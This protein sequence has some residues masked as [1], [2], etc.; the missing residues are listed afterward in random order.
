[1]KKFLTVIAISLITFHISAK[2]NV[3]VILTDDQGWG[4]LSINGNTAIDTPNVDRL[5]RDGAMFDRFYV[6]PVCAPTRAEFLTGRH[7]V[8]TGV[9]GVTAGGERINPD[10][11]LIS[12]LFQRSGYKTAAFGKWHSGM[13]FPYHPNARGFDEFY[14][15]CSGHWGNYYD[16]MIDHNGDITTGTGYVNNDFTERAMD[17]I[18]THQEKPFFVYLPLNTPHSPMQVPDRW[19]NKFKDLELT[20]DHRD[21]KKENIDHTRAALAM[22]ENID[23]NVGRLLSKLDELKLAENTIVVYFCDNGPNGNRWNGDMRGKKGSTDEG[24]V[25]SPLFIRW[26]GKIKPGTE[27]LPICSAYDLLPTLADL[28]DVPM[29]GTKPIDGTSLKPLLF[30]EVNNWPDRT[31][32]HYW[33]KLSIRTPGYRLDQKGNLYDMVT[34]PGQRTAINDQVPETA[35]SLKEYA[36]KWRAEMVSRHG[37][38]FDHRPFV[39]G[40]PGAKMTQ[41]PA[42]DGVGKGGIKRSCKHANDSYFT[43]WTSLEDSIEWHCEVGQTGKYKVELFYTCPDADAGSTVELSFNDEKMVGKITKAHNP[44]LFGMERDRVERTESY[45]KDFKRVTFGTIILK[46]GEGTLKLQALEILGAQVMDFRLML[47][48]RID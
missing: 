25:R 28:T 10:E 15:F 44:P 42:R 29:S 27:V 9:Y 19:W 16:T 11:V 47:L 1:M 45:N 3:V 17:Y 6:S 30:G 40:H 7:H 5:A 26:P 2:P 4:D 22:C 14:G 37:K 23:W 36:E 13:Q 12:E 32:A 48:T 38:E 34:D 35:A 39:I 43:N 8:R 46:K 41:I 20:Q 21:K 33:H 31:L 24:G 18:E